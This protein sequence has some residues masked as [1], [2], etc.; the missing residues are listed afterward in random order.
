M[1]LWSGVGGQLLPSAIIIMLLWVGGQLCTRS[2]EG[3]FRNA[4]GKKKDT[5]MILVDRMDKEKR[6]VWTK[7][8]PAPVERLALCCTVS[9]SM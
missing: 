2:L 5:E 8:G 4:L 9:S 1:L 6:C 7:N 3:P